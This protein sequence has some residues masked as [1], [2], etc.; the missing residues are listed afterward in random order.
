MDR[1]H[2]VRIAGDDSPVFGLHWNLRAD[3]MEKTVASR[4]KFGQ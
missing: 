1:C 2:K 4:K 3:A